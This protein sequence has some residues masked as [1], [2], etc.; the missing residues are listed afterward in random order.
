MALTIQ[1]RQQVRCG[2]LTRLDN[3]VSM[4]EKGPRVRSIDLFRGSIAGQMECGYFV[5]ECRISPLQ[6][7]S[8]MRHRLCCTRSSACRSTCAV[9]AKC[10]GC[11]A[12]YVTGCGTVLY[13]PGPP[14]AVAWAQRPPGRY[15][16]AVTAHRPQHEATPRSMCRSSNEDAPASTQA[17]TCFSV[18]A[19]HIQMY[20]R[21]IIENH[22]SLRKRFNK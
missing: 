9:R 19:L 7:A 18:T 17:R 15:S 3:G 20:M 13:P 4:P 8:V 6:A 10:L 14:H 21:I 12:G 16:T 5:T 2:A 11:G 1:A 22:R